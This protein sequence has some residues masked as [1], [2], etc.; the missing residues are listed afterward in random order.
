MSLK[1]RHT[2]RQTD[3]ETGRHTHTNTHMDTHLLP[4]G[5]EKISHL[6]IWGNI[7]HEWIQIKNPLSLID[8]AALHNWCSTDPPLILYTV[9]FHF[10]ECVYRSGTVNSNTVNSK[11]HL[12]RSYCEIFGYNCPNISCL[13]YTV[14]SNFHLI[15]SKTLPTNDFE[16]TV[17]DL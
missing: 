17:P 15:R 9:C 13:K 1:P 10:S 8:R 4:R 6:A 5:S 11:F 14:N 7:R 12:I 3:R 2:Y 16:L